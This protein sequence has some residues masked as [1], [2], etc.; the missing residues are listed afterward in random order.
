MT[1]SR[2]HWISL[3]AVVIIILIFISVFLPALFI[4]AGIIP[5]VFIAPFGLVII[6]AP[7]P[8]IPPEMR[9]YHG[10]FRSGDFIDK[11]IGKSGII[12]PDVISE[13][14]AKIIAGHVLEQY[15]GLPADAQPPSATTGYIYTHNSSANTIIASRPDGVTVFY[16]R[17]IDNL[18]VVGLSDRIIVELDNSGELVWFFKR[19]RSLEYSGLNESI[20]S[21]GQALIRLKDDEILDR[22]HG[23]IFLFTINEISYGYYEKSESNPDIELTP[24]WIVKGTQLRGDP[25]TI[26]IPA[27]ADRALKTPRP[28]SELRTAS[29]LTA[30]LNRM[31]SGP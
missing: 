11:N 25:M 28:Y 16:H 10:P 27:R 14:E 24:V 1:L 13:N 6:D 2:K 29:D 22:P 7:M 19:W 8:D 4:N 31:D 9:I 15:G 23:C 3:A 26:I 30:A 17:H 5:P 12:K 21:P 18:P 20:I